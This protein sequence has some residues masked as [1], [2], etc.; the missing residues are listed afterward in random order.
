MFPPYVLSVKYYLT[1][2]NLFDTFI[3]Y[4]INNISFIFRHITSHNLYD[5]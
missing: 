5:I 3:D 4:K 1:I 2:K